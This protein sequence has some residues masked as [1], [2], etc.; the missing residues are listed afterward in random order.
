M[1]F[2]VINR[3]VPVACSPVCSVLQS[4]V[5]TR[6]YTRCG[7]EDLVSVG[8]FHCAVLVGRNLCVRRLSVKNKNLET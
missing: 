3:V 6:L 4:A 7:K 5:C 8:C 2:S 1:H